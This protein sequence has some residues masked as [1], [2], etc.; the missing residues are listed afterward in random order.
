MLHGTV[1]RMTCNVCG[2]VDLPEYLTPAC[3]DC[4]SADTRTLLLQPCAD[5]G[6]LVRE[7]GLVMPFNLDGSVHS[8]PERWTITRVN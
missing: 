6:D 5:C 1:V 4:G 8:H 2:K 7:V 3:R